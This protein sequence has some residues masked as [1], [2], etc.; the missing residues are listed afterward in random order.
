MNCKV[1]NITWAKHRMWLFLTEKVILF[2]NTNKPS[3]V[4]VVL[5]LGTLSVVMQLIYKINYMYNFYLWYKIKNKRMLIVPQ[6]FVEI[7]YVSNISINFSAI[8]S[9]EWMPSNSLKSSVSSRK[10]HNLSIKWIV[11]PMYALT[12]TEV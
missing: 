10:F 3:C 5:L 9:S 8:Y 6:T 1:Q 4:N 7:L 12:T 11:I 2:S